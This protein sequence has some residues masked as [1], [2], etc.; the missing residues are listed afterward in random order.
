MD[1]NAVLQLRLV[2]IGLGVVL[3]VV[4]SFYIH[5]MIR[6]WKSK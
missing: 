2:L 3:V 6:L 4:G 1:S 5:A